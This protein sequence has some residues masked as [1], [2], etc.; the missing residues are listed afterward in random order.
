MTFH[1]SASSFRDP[2]LA[3]L[4]PEPPRFDGDPYDEDPY[5]PDP[6]ARF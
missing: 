4:T 5:Y 6:Y 3:T 1:D 2:R